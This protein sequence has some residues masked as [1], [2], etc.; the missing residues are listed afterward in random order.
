MILS[1]PPFPDAAR[2]SGLGAAVETPARTGAKQA[3]EENS[4]A[5][6]EM[7]GR[8]GKEGAADERREVM[9]PIHGQVR[10]S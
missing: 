8:V 7:P 4:N 2:T 3:A 1:G 6:D 9:H 10:R 5:A